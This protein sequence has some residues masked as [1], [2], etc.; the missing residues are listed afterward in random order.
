VHPGG[1]DIPAKSARVEYVPA[2]QMPTDKEWTAIKKVKRKFSVYGDYEYCDE[3]D[4]RISSMLSKNSDGP[5]I[6]DD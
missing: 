4:G 5:N 1:F 3:F 6:G 2:D